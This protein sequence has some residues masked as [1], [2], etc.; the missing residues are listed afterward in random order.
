MWSASLGLSLGG[1]MHARILERQKLDGF[2]A[3]QAGEVQRFLVHTAAEV[4]R[5]GIVGEPSDDFG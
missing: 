1:G 3:G 4:V 5:F 2:V